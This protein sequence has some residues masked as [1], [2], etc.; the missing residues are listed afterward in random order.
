MAR[1]EKSQKIG[2][3]GELDIRR[4]FEE[5]GFATAQINPDFGEDFF[6][7]G[8]DESYIEPFSQGF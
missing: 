6:V 7:F 8:E 4:M 2:R 3:R 5:E 1:N